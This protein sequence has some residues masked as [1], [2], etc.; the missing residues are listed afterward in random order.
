MPDTTTTEAPKKPRARKKPAAQADARARA[1]GIGTDEALSQSAKDGEEQERQ[2][3]AE[4]HAVMDKR[5]KGYDAYCALRSQMKGATK[6]QR[7]ELEAKQEK[8]RPAFQAWKKAYNQLL[9]QGS[10]QA[11]AEG[12]DGRGGSATR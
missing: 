6:T 7:A 1:A 11:E 4:L 8:H 10:C 3:E 5:Q 12:R 2:S 9:K